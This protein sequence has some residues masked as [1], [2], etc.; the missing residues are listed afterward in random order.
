MGMA[1]VKI[2]T[3]EEK[4]MGEMAIGRGTFTGMDAEGNTITTGK[5][6]NVVKMVDGEWKVYYDIFNYD[7]PMTA[8]E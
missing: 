7:A 1:K 8:P 4:V 5:W 6:S 3:I 2:D